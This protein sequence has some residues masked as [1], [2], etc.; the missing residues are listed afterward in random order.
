MS[1]T[2]ST[3]RKLSRIREYVAA[4]L[5][6][7]ILATTGILILSSLKYI[8]NSESFSRVNELLETLIPLLTFVLGYYFSKTST[9]PRAEKAEETAR[10]AAVDAVQ[11]I[12]ARARADSDAKMAK[13]ETRDVK[14]TLAELGQTT[15]KYLSNLSSLR[16][17]T[18]GE[19]QDQTESEEKLRLELRAALLH[20]ERHI[21]RDA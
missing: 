7:I 19:D 11:A 15:E 12:E 14:S 4:A 21:A 9:E 10:A 20:A 8:D 3:D 5:A 1:E 17:G 18:L 2:I 13:D 6:L 16:L